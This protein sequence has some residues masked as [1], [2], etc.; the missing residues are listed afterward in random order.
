MGFHWWANEYQNGCTQLV[1]AHVRDEGAL[2]KEPDL[3]D[4]V[5]RAL[6]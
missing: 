1:K 4:L 2:G 5:A 3:I 6:G